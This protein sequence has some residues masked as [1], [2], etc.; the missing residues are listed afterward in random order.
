MIGIYGVMTYTVS[1][2]TSEVGIR[3]A[4][5]AGRGQVT[6][7]ILRQGGRLMLIGLAIGLPIT[8]GLSK[9]LSGVLYSVGTF[10]PLALG[11]A[12]LLLVIVALPALLLPARRAA[13]IDPASS[14]RA[15]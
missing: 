10:E 5:G 1:Q 2:R 8:L 6:A 14:L 12:V 3:M 13:R 7:M 9:V 15:D 11:A 4:L